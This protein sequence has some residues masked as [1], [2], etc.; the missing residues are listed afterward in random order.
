MTAELEAVIEHDRKGTARGSAVAADTVYRV[1]LRSEI[2][3]CARTSLS[4][5]PV[6][7]IGPF[8]G[9]HRV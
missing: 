1:P 5:P 6:A 8:N 2:N 7:V 3:T 4:D 9:R